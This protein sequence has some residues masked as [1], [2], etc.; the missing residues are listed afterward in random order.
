MIN[1]A[2]MQLFTSNAMYNAHTSGLGRGKNNSGR[3]SRGGTP[4]KN[5]LF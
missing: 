2:M 3:R 4:I 1:N 5:L